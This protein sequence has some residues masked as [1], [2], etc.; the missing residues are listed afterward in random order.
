MQTSL[1]PS[2]GYLDPPFDPSVTQYDLILT[3][4]GQEVSV[5]ATLTEAAA[6]GSILV[7]GLAVHSGATSQKLHV[8]YTWCVLNKGRR[9]LWL[10]L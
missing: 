4:Q 8:E 10:P 7:N 2:V 5:A 9:C 1:K 6:S 3:G